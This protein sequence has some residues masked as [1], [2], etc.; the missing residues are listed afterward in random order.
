MQYILQQK[1]AL[2]VH[3]HCAVLDR[4]VATAELGATIVEGENRDTL[5]KTAQGL[6]EP[7]LPSQC[8]SGDFFQGTAK[9][10]ILL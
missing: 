9:T 3:I 10:E 1:S 7:I 2:S 5:L 4:N 6:V 8:S